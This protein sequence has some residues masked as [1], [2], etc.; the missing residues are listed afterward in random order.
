MSVKRVVLLMLA[1]LAGWQQMAFGYELKGQINNLGNAKVYLLVPAN[2]DFVA[3]DS[4]L[5]NAGVFVMKGHIEAPTVARLLVEGHPYPLVYFMLENTTYQITSFVSEKNRLAVPDIKGGTLQ[6]AWNNYNEAYKDIYE[7][8]RVAGQRAYQLK[9]AG[10]TPAD[11]LQQLETLITQTEQKETAFTKDAIFRNKANVIGTYLMST[12]LL[13][14]EYNEA[15]AMVARFVADLRTDYYYKDVVTRLDKI[16]NVLNGK[17]APAFQLKD[18]LGNTISLR[19]FKGK[20]V[21]LDFWASWCGPCRAENPELVKLYQ[22]VK[23]ADVVFMGISLDHDKAAWKKA[24]QQ[25]GLNWIHAS[26]LKGWK[27]EMCKKYAV[28]AVPH[29]FLINPQGD[30]VLSGAGMA[31]IKTALEKRK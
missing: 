30:I 22:E 12:H 1:L 3:V 2:G 18:T 23:A 5:A 7:V 6:N 15:R 14:Y 27:S 21:V 25:D 24:V 13:S 29:K 10:N 16:S 8:R 19:D 31:D 4:T 9:K 26:D 11:T 17:P 20:W 28:E